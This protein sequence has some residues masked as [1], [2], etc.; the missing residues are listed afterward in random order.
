MLLPGLLPANPN[1]SPNP[2][3]FRDPTDSDDESC[4]SDH[5]KKEKICRALQAS[6]LAT[7]A[8]LK[9]SLMFKCYQAAHDTYTAC[10]SD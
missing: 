6:V 2:N 9:G 5:E 3:V 1:Y 7:C 4:P 8:S 10:M